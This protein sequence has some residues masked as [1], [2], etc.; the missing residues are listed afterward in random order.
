VRDI[1]ERIR[2][3]TSRAGEVIR[4]LRDHVAKRS[5]TRINE[6]INGVV[7]EAVELG[8]VG[9]RHQ[10]VQTSLIMDDTVG[11]AL[12]D[13]IQIGQVLINL[14]RN[15]VEAMETSDRKELVVTTRLIDATVQI[16]VTDSGPGIAA[17]IAEQLFQPFVTTKSAGL[18][19]GLSICRDI[20]ETHGGQLTAAPG[21]NGG[22]V[23]TISLPH[24]P[25]A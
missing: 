5:T 21:A 25:A 16:A 4:R 7:R 15:A 13:R 19:L 12:I 11:S 8:L 20:I 9:T 17:E 22:A 6:N 10:G 24:P 23:F 2:Q 14:V 3:Q 18:G 1:V